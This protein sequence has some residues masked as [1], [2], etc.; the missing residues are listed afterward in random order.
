MEHVSSCNLN[1]CDLKFNPRS[2][3]I[4]NY[5]AY[6]RSECE[7]HREEAIIN[8]AF[9]SSSPIPFPASINPRQQTPKVCAAGMKTRSQEERPVASWSS[10]A[11]DHT[12]I[13]LQDLS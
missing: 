13:V 7:R 10:T 6:K 2:L 11:I 5:L 12:Q 8:P 9:F 1:P 4:Q 3:L